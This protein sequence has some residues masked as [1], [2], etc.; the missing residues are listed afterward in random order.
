M[1]TKEEGEVAHVESQVLLNDKM[2]QEPLNKKKE[3][4]NLILNNNN[5][6]NSTPISM[7]AG[8]SIG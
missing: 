5:I 8:H 6:H 1:I 7:A 3:T 4:S 2:E